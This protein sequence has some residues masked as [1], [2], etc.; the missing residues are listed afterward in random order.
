MSDFHQLTHSKPVRLCHGAEAL[1]ALELSSLPVASV[2]AGIASV[3]IISSAVCAA[4]YTSRN[5]LSVSCPHQPP[6]EVPGS[7][8]EEFLVQG[9]YGSVAGI[10]AGGQGG[11]RD[12]SLEI[13]NID[14]LPLFQDDNRLYPWLKAPLQFRCLLY[15]RVAIVLP[16][17]RS[18][19][20]RRSQRLRH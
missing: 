9:R 8:D 11:L 6:P 3:P 17:Y 20:T 19:A 10:H 16:L 2:K 14:S 7:Q 18:T 1:T 5:P 15:H 12:F 4:S 13:I